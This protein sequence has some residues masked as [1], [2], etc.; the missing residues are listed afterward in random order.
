M[1]RGPWRTVHGTGLLSFGK[2]F[3]GSL[4]HELEDKCVLG[5]FV[6]PKINR[7]KQGG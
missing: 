5:S 3:S 2:I 1:G 7:L 6:D 4:G